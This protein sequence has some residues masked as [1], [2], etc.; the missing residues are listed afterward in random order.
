[1]EEDTEKKGTRGKRKLDRKLKEK[2]EV[3]HLDLLA[4]ISAC[5]SADK[6]IQYFL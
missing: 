2:R 6:A 5:V 4:V 3:N 1:M